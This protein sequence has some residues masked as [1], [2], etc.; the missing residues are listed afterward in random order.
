MGC[1]KTE[2]ISAYLDAE[3]DQAE[4]PAFEAHVHDCPDCSRTL[5]DLRA[6]RR[7]FSGAGLQQAPYGFATRVMARTRALD[8]KRSPWFSPVLTGFAEAAVL[9]M[10]ITVGI[11]AGRAMTN[12][13]PAAQATNQASAFSL[14]LFDATP[15]GSPGSAY[16]TMTEARNEK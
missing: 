3:L 11:F 7:A 14:D 9:L 4:K 5:D 8:K 16:L 12:S 1:P 2:H 13:S 10:V 6:L 15:P